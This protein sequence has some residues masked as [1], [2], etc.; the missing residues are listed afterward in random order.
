MGSIDQVKGSETIMGAEYSIPEDTK[1]T[2][3]EIKRLHKRFCKIDIDNS[4]SLSAEEIQAI[5]GLEANPLV[6]RVI[7]I[8]DT[9]NNKEID[10]KEFLEGISMFIARE[11]TES[12]LKFIFRM[13]DIDNDGFI[14]N[15]ELFMVLKLM[16]GNNLGDTQLQ[17]IVDKTIQQFDFD[18]D[19]KISFDE[20]CS[21]VGDLDTYKKMTVKV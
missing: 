18:G 2:V 16:I 21:A 13:Y 14:T 5:P 9:D 20:F 17:Q 12:K 4:H 19:G 11:G 10:F 8:F 3:A 7:D 6:H 15:A 1:F